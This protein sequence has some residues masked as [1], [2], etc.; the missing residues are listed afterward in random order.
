MDLLYSFRLLDY[1]FLFA[2]LAIVIFSLLVTFNRQLLAKYENHPV[3]GPVVES[4]FHLTKIGIF[5]SFLSIGISLA[6]VLNRS[7]NAPEKVLR[8]IQ[9]VIAGVTTALLC[10]A[11]AVGGAIIVY[12][13]ERHNSKAKADDSKVREGELDKFI[14]EKIKELAKVL[15]EAVV[16]GQGA[17]AQKLVEAVQQFASDAKDI[18]D[19]QKRLETDFR[20]ITTR[21]TSL[22][23]TFERF[24]DIAERYDL[25]KTKDSWD[26]F[27]SSINKFSQS[28]QPFLKSLSDAHDSTNH[29]LIGAANLLEE[30]IGRLKSI[31]A[32]LL[33]FQ[34]RDAIDEAT[35]SVESL[36]LASQAMKSEL[37]SLSDVISLETKAFSETF[38]S[39]FGNLSDSLKATSSKTIDDHAKLLNEVIEQVQKFIGAFV[40]YSNENVT[41]LHRVA[42]EIAAVSQPDAARNSSGPYLAT[43]AQ[44]INA[45]DTAR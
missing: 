8:E 3:L 30:Q 6:G 14:N 4:R 11:L 41:T 1:V 16:N 45:P 40:E 15:G 39:S 32:D 13:W 26:E 10:S 21:A 24:N 44:P 38:V 42:G 34:N 29:G 25:E 20:S 19:G 28:V 35:T 36:R 7:G 22:A 37:H 5:F 18:M 27:I 33:I 12:L 2:I 9:S 43:E 17:I 23:V 31:R